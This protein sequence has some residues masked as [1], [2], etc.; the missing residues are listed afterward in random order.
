MRCAKCGKELTWLPHALDGH[1]KVRCRKCFG[2]A[3]SDADSPVADVFD[4]AYERRLAA[5]IRD[6][7]SEAA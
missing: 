6:R 7:W 3:P 1:V 4:R 2:A 5:K